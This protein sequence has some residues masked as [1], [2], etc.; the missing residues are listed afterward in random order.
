MSTSIIKQLLINNLNISSPDVLDII[1]S[2]CFYDIK[3][4]ETI[5]FIKYKK[6][7]IHFLFKN[8]TYSRANPDSDN[9]ATDDDFNDDSEHW[10]FW[11]EDET[12]GP[13]PQFQAINCKVCGNFISINPNIPDNILCLCH[14][15]NADWDDDDSDWFEY[16]SDDNDDA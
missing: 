14:I 8:G 16:D 9:F 2:Y 12:D 15:N 13:N 6:E 10:A 7:R 1:K 4:W 11:A 5:S 3:A